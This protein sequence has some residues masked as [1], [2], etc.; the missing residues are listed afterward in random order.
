[1]V[2]LVCVAIRAEEPPPERSKELSPTNNFTR[3]LVCFIVY[4][5]HRRRHHHRIFIC[6]R[7]KGKSKKFIT[8]LLRTRR[9]YIHVY[10]VGLRDLQLK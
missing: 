5:H 3:S 8:R 6:T 4:Y 10:I 1:M 2:T 9:V 7:E